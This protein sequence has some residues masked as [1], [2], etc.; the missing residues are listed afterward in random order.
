MDVTPKVFAAI[1]S[2]L[3]SVLLDPTLCERP[4]MQIDHVFEAELKA[5]YGF[6]GLLSPMVET[7]LRMKPQSLGIDSKPHRPRLSRRCEPPLLTWARV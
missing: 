5:A 2:H 4:K 6:F 3:R 1:V 7:S